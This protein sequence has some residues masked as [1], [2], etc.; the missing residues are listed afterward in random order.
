MRIHVNLQAAWAV[1]ALEASR[2]NVPL[3]TI[4]DRELAIAVSNIIRRVICRR[5]GNGERD[6]GSISCSLR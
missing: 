5:F 6:N 3:V 2:T 4:R 1:E